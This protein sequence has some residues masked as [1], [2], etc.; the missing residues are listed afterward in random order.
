MTQTHLSFGK[1]EKLCSLKL[2]QRLFAEGKSFVK[3]PLRISQLTL[4]TLPEPV[5]CQVLVSVSKKKFKRANKRNRIK[6]QIRESYRRNKHLL[7]DT[8]LAQDKKMALAF[9]YIPS[10]ELTTAEIEKGMI[11]ALLHL[12]EQLEKQDDPN[13]IL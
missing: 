8:L 10:E 13:D 9:I 11:K 3:Y 7:T 1:K 2:I 4:P 5:C 12:K 6:R